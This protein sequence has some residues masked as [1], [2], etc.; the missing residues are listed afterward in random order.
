M[1]CLGELRTPVF[2]GVHQ[3]VSLFKVFSRGGGESHI[4]FLSSTRTPKY[5]PRKLHHRC[6]SRGVYVL[7]TK[8]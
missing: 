7:F 2:V 1:T 4:A 5:F 6:R 8:P 3:P